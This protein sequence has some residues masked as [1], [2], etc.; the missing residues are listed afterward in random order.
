MQPDLESPPGPWW[1]ADLA[2]K[3]SA[4]GWHTEFEDHRRGTE[5]PA[6]VQLF[7]VKRSLEYTCK[8]T[9]A[10]AALELGPGGSG[11]TKSQFNHTGRIAAQA[12]FG[13]FHAEPDFYYYLDKDLVLDMTGIAPQIG[14][15]SYDRLGDLHPERCPA[16]PDG[17]AMLLS[18]TGILL[19]SRILW[20]AFS[21]LCPRPTR[22]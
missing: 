15:T 2:G 7:R 19:C 16:H 22:R 13:L 10:N 9:S 21:K 11:W 8:R 14:T 6:I 18:T 1:T 4:D 3:G 5:A 17:P 20:S 12:G